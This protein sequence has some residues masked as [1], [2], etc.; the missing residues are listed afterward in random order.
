MNRKSV[1]AIW[2][3]YSIKYSVMSYL[4]RPPNIWRTGL[5]NILEMFWKRGIKKKQKQMI[6]YLNSENN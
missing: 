6:N 5:N 2:N 1:L 4:I 3:I